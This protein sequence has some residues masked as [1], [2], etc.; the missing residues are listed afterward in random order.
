MSVVP[1]PGDLVLPGHGRIQTDVGAPLDVGRRQADEQLLLAPAG[2]DVLDGADFSVRGDDREPATLAV[3]VQHGLPPQDLR[4]CCPEKEQEPCPGESARRSSSSPFPPAEGRIAT[5]AP[6]RPAYAEHVAAR[7][8]DTRSSGARPIGTGLR[9]GW[10]SRMDG[11][12]TPASVI[13]E[14]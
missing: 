11:L 13:V 4:W 12:A 2:L 10:T 1:V 8:G 7:Q 14:T 5:P 9:P 3:P 6:R